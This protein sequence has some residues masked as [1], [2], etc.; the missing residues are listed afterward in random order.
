MQRKN[1]TISELKELK[2]EFP[3]LFDIITGKSDYDNILQPCSFD[4][5]LS[6]EECDTIEDPTK[7][8]ERRFTHLKMLKIFFEESN[9]EV[10]SWRYKRHK[11]IHIYKIT[12]WKYLLKTSQIDKKTG[13]SGCFFFLISKKLKVIYE[14]HWDWTNIIYMFPNTDVSKIKNITSASGLYLL[15]PLSNKE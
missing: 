6:L 15:N 1:I 12:D 7:D 10:Y 13:L 8:G 9:N 5:Y 11:R 4:H 2:L 14:E 3:N